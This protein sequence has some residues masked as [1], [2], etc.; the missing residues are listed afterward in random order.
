M[1][2][3]LPTA[4]LLGAVL[5]RFA[6]GT[7]V[8]LVSVASALVLA[9]LVPLAL[10]VLIAVVGIVVDLIV[11]IATIAAGAD[12]G[13]GGETGDAAVGIHKAGLVGW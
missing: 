9:L 2:F 1:I 12:S 4:A 6:A 11:G 8:A 10:L 7:S 13:T 5:R 3:C